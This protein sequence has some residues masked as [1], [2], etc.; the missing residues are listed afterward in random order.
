MCLNLVAYSLRAWG[1]I[2][3]E[4]PTTSLLKIWSPPSL[5][6]RERCFV[7]LGDRA[8]EITAVADFE[9]RLM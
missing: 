6:R 8:H 5:R 1:P 2:G 7:D 3:E 9:A 4:K